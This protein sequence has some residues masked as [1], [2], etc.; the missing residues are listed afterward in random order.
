MNIRKLLT[1]VALLTVSLSV[2]GEDYS[3]IVN[4]IKQA[5]IPDRRVDLWEISV[6]ELDTCH[7]SLVGKTTNAKAKT[8]LLQ[9]FNDAEV[10]FVDSIAVLVRG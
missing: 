1:V 7:V 3:S 5:Y 4:G 9:A 8:A 10:A 6:N 2:L